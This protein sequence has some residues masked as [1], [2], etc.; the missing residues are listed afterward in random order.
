[1]PDYFYKATDAEG[2]E[3]RFRIHTEP[4]GDHWMA[5]CDAVNER[6]EPETGGA[7]LA[8][9]FYGFDEG[10]ARRRMVTAVENSYEEIAE[11]SGR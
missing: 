10:Q 6:G 2:Q 11:D 4:Q 7:R 3:S 8:P 9:Q 5:T 1:M